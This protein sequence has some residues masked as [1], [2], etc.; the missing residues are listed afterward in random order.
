MIFKYKGDADEIT[1]EPGR[2]QIEAWGASGGGYEQ[3]ESLTSTTGGK[4]AYAMAVFDITE[5]TTLYVYVGGQGSKYSNVNEENGGYNGGGS[6]YNGYGGGGAS[7]VRL[8]KGEWND[9]NSLLSRIVVAAGGGGSSK[10][11]EL[12]NYRNRWRRAEMPKMQVMEIL[13]Q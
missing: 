8:L 12:D 5:E 4:G 1:L 3:S 6:S 7:D 10:A 9:T 11:N 13:Y 2:Y